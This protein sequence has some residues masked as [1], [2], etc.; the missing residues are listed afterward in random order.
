MIEQKEVAL[1]ELWWVSETEDYKQIKICQQVKLR[2]LGD[3]SVFSCVSKAYETDDWSGEDILNVRVIRSMIW[4]AFFY[5]SLSC[6]FAKQQRVKCACIC[7]TPK[8]LD[9]TEESK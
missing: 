2:D 3:L 8:M 5:L 9:T 4:A 6:S 1:I 7:T